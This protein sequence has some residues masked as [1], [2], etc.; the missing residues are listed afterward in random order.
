[1][2]HAFLI[3]AHSQY[4]LLAT[5]A[6]LLDH[7]NN[8][9]YILI[10]KKSTPPS[11]S[12]FKQKKSGLFILDKRIDIRWGD[13]SQI[14]AELLLFRTALNNGN[15][16]YFHLLSGVDLPIKPLDYIFSF[17]EANNNKEFVGFSND[18]NWQYKIN[19]YHLLTRFYRISGKKKEKVDNIRYISEFIINKL[20]KRTDNNTTF[21]KGANWCSITY[22]FCKYLISKEQYILKRFRY[23]SCADEIFLQ[24]ILWN[25]PFRNN[26]YCLEDEYSSCLREIDWQRGNPYVWGRSSGDLAVLQK[27][28]KLFARKFSME[29]PEIIQNI[30]NIVK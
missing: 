27:S 21:K 9:I 11:R 24:T 28:D 12:I 22:G 1:M 20:F 3:I 29:Y 16:S 15:Y 30:R 4:E 7:P 6:E 18:I 25:S 26:I 14:K 10:D 17:F 23:T 8:D 13:I 19:R 5:L 2:K